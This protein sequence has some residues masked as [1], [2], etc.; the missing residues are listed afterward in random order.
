MRTR[1]VCRA[2]QLVIPSDKEL[3]GNRS[4][5]TG[6]DGGAGRALGVQPKNRAHID[7][8]TSAAKGVNAETRST[9]VFSLSV[10][11]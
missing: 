4:S 9:S 6:E 5:W 11:G 2:E 8:A 1:F 10:L 7:A 3:P